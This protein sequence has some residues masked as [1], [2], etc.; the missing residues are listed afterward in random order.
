MNLSVNYLIASKML[1]MFPRHPMQNAK[2][3]G[4]PSAK[5]NIEHLKTKNHTLSLIFTYRVP[6]WS[7]FVYSKTSKEDVLGPIIVWK[8]FHQVFLCSCSKI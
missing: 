8:S 4:K 6:M 3:L 1:I 5:D 7:Q 2:M